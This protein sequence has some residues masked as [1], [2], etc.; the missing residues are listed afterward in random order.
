MLV[1]HFSRVRTALRDREVL[2]ASLRELGYEVAERG[3]I[4]SRDGVREV[5]LSISTKNGNG[6]GFVKDGDGCY[7]LV[8]DW[9]GMGRKDRQI[10]DRL[11]GTLARVQRNY[12][13]RMIREQTEKE[14]FSLVERREEEDG[15]IR[16]M[17]RRWT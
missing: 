11:N 2:T 5:D 12:A 8:A 17:V 4:R 7:N 9:W 6:I 10:L 13:E 3:T 1:S 15:S 16:I 14:G